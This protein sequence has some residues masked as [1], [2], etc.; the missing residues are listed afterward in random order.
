MRLSA[1]LADNLMSYHEKK[2]THKTQKEKAKCLKKTKY[3][4]KRK[5]N[6]PKR[7]NS[8]DSVQM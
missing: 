3:P 6:A 8:L 4:K 2:V 1:I 7:Q 5:Q